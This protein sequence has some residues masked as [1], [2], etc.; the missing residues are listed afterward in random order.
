[1]KS[2]LKKLFEDDK[3]FGTDSIGFDNGFMQNQHGD[4]VDYMILE[5]VDRFD[6]YLNLYDEGKPPY[7]NILAKGSAKTKEEAQML[8]IEELDRFA[9]S[10]DII[11]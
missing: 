6:V 9:Y 7:R 11:H 1:M 5:Y 8:A 4:L 3:S 2:K 10:N